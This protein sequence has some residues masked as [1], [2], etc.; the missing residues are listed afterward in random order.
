M[1]TE[2]PDLFAGSAVT[3]AR[4]NPCDLAESLRRRARRA[5]ARQA[6]SFENRSWTYGEL[7]SRVEHFAAVLAAGGVGR[8]DRVGWLGFNDPFVL[9]ALFASASLGAIFVPLN[10]RLARHELEF[11]IGDAGLHTL[12]V[13]DDHRAT[14][15]DA[16]AAGTLSCCRRF[17]R[18]GADTL[19]GWDATE[20]LT[21]PLAIEPR[22]SVAGDP[23]AIMYTSGT[24]G[25]PKGVMLTH[26]NLWAN[27]INWVLAG[28]L[29]SSDVVLNCAPLF[30]VGG[31]CVTVLP[32]LLAGGHVVLQRA[33]VPA[34][35][36]A[37]IAR[38]RITLSFAVP[39]M[40]LAVTQ[41]E[42]FASTDLSSLRL[43]IGGGAPVPEPLLRLFNGRGIPMSQ[44][45]GMTES[46]SAVTFLEAERAIDKLGSCGKATLLSEFR[47]VDAEGVVITEAGIKGEICLRGENVTPGYWNRPEA[48]R[49]AI[50]AEG[51]LHSGDVGY[52]D[53]EGFLYVCDRLKDMI[54]SGGENIY[55]AEIENVL[56]DHPAVFEVAIVGAPDA[57]WGERVVAFVA[58]RPGHNMTLEELRDFTGQRLARYKLPRELRLIDAL[59]RNS[60]GK[61][62][63]AELRERCATSA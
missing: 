36:L 19:D 2:Q 51:W 24:T 20:P 33:F 5:P 30:H 60:N 56:Y 35:Y 9:I 3:P 13:D 44:G 58:T 63:K 41:H 4:P 39:A 62:L 22:T 40:L 16:R 59:P 46:S 29:G 54:I 47:L 26:G 17:L 15:V 18:P 8:G 12:I 32:A 38:H 21:P 25:R 1:T 49:E 37:A 6:L 14:I 61:V 57:Q 53:A 55:P 23:A 31:L 11:I 48:T 34:D 27:S 50:D 45:F 52:C 42:D 28:D 43:I 7:Q 10:F